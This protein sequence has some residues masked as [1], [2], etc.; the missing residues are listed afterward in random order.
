MHVA[1]AAAAIVR[2]RQVRVHDLRK[3]AVGPVRMRARAARVDFLH[4][5][6]HARTVLD[7]GNL[8]TGNPEAGHVKDVLGVVKEGDGV[9]IAPEQ[10]NFA[11]ELN[12]SLEGRS[13]PEC[14]VPGLLTD[15]VLRMRTPY[16][17]P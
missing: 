11:V 15:Q 8:E 1:G 9:V 3:K 7:H 12:E 17:K 6:P 10:Q 16:D 13:L 4:L 5:S 2:V 14:E